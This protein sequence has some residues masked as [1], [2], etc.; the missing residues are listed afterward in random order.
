MGPRRRY[1]MGPHPSTRLS[2]G[3]QN[4]LTKQTM[5][6][7]ISS[8]VRRALVFLLAGAL[9]CGSEIVLPDPPAGDGSVALTKIGGDAQI[10]TVGE[11]LAGPLIVQVFTES[12]DP[13]PGHRVAF[14]L[15]DPA[16]GTVSPDTAETDE[17][18]R[19]RAEWVLGTTIGAKVVVAHLVG[20]TTQTQI[21]EF[22]A[23]ARA[24]APAT[25][26]AES[27]QAQPGLRRQPVGTPPIVQVVDRYGNPVE[28]VEVSWRV[29]A[30]EGDVPQPTMLTDAE[31]KVTTQWTLGNRIGVHKLTAAIGDVSVSPVTFTA[32]VLF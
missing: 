14:A 31:G 25:L 19:A 22:T 7:T 16:A 5:P 27:V 13:A 4:I 23:T 15:S 28:G 1:S 32:N 30:G 9:G 17:Q 3:R 6:H 21:A 8:S 11:R 18:G 2:P 10:G 26:S 24:A 29:T 12:R 20:D